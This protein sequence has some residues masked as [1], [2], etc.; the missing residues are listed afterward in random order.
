M[1]THENKKRRNS[2]MVEVS[3]FAP[4]LLAARVH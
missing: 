3:A 4:L 2:Q 1:A